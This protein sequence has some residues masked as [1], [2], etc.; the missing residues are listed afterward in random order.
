MSKR[1]WIHE[2]L[3][4]R[5]NKK[6]KV[7]QISKQLNIPRTTL[8]SLLRRFAHSGLSWP[9]PEDCTSE[10]LAQLLYP[11]TLRQQNQPESVTQVAAP[12]VPVPPRRRPNFPPEFRRHLV[13]LSMQPGANVARIA[14][15]HGIND[16]LLFNWR[17]RYRQELASQHGEPVTLLPVSVSAVP[18]PDIHPTVAESSCDSPL[19]CEVAI[20]GGTLRL[21]GAITPALLCV[22][23]NE[24]KGGQ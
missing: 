19:S 23:L 20:P 18:G 13:E 17:H 14:R 5:F 6:I 22:L 2:A 10:H 21:Q 7:N 12:D 4:L 3:T 11:G 1:A 15:E 16:N 24:L 9:V 8:Q